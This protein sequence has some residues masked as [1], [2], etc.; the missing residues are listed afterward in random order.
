MLIL[1]RFEV[2]MGGYILL[3]IPQGFSDGINML[4]ELVPYALKHDRTIIWSLLLYSLTDLD[5]IFDF[6]QFPVKVLCGEKHLKNV[7]YS[8][9]EP[10]CFKN[11]LDGHNIEHQWQKCPNYYSIGGEIMEF[12]QTKTYHDSVLLVYH[13]S[14]GGPT[15][16]DNI[17]FKPTFLEKFYRQR[18]VFDK[19]VAIHLRAT[20]YP[21]Y[22]E[23][24]DMAKVD[25]FVEK[26][27]DIPVYIASDNSMLVEKLCEK[28]QQLVKPLS[29]KKITEQYR[30]LHHSFG[31]TDPEC[32]TNALIDILMCASADD[33]LQSRGGF[34]RL[35]WVLSQNKKLLQTLTLKEPE[36]I[37]EIPKTVTLVKKA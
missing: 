33:F 23:E 24:E 9:I 11:K 15:T 16:L 31:N 14:N 35:I 8:R 25:T 1:I 30:S 21:G 36:P 3:R 17:R 18:N 20:D 6:S 28:H 2:I 29:Y 26:H 10:R 22:K 7:V 32:L 4:K 34:S 27:P 5:S 12:D 13:N 19:F 37:V